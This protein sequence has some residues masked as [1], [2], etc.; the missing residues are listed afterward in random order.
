ML[1]LYHQTRAIDILVAQCDWKPLIELAITADLLRGIIME[2]NAIT[3]LRKKVSVAERNVGGMFAPGECRMA[4]EHQ[5]A[6]G[7]GVKVLEALDGVTEM[8]YGKTA[9]SERGFSNDVLQNGWLSGLSGL[10]WNQGDIEGRERKSTNSVLQLQVGSLGSK[11]D[12]ND[13]KN[14]P[15]RK[16][17]VPPRL[18]ASR[19]GTVGNFSWPA[20]KRM[21]RNDRVRSYNSIGSGSPER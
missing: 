2:P 3:A 7:G 12:D 5:R 16:P 14:Y 15:V 21:E 11:Q 1:E 9:H 6:T 20:R 4:I 13:G 8:V 17:T 19:T 10:V 18:E